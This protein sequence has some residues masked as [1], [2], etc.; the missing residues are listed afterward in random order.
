MN[1]VDKQAGLIGS[2]IM[3]KGCMVGLAS[4]G[5]HSW[6]FTRSLLWQAQPLNYRYTYNWTVGRNLVDAYN[7]LFDM[8][9]SGDYEYL[10]LMEEDTIAPPE[11]WVKLLNKMRYN[12]DIFAVTGV[13]PRKLGG[14]PTPF[15]YRGNLNGP[16]L[17]WVYGEFFEVT[18]IPLG[19]LILRI[20]ML[21]EMDEFVGDV[22]IKDYPV[23]GEGKWVKAY[24]RMNVP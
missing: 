11:T 4:V 8:A 13:Y 23:M 17:D 16:Y 18:G 7:I 19:C 9:K 15:F 24:C 2:N 21:K 10:F 14:D 3:R 22:Y 1:T 5:H 20:D 6:E 12:K